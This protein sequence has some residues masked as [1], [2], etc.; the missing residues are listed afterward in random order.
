MRNLH[1]VSGGLAALLIL[2]GCASIGGSDQTASGNS[3]DKLK[4]T[5]KGTPEERAERRRS[6][7]LNSYLVLMDSPDGSPSQVTIAGPQGQAVVGQSGGAAL[8]DGSDTVFAVSEERFNADF[9]KAIGARPPL[10]EHFRLYFE[11]DSDRLTAESQ[12][13][14]PRIL[15]AVKQR[16][17]PDVSVVGHTDT[18]GSAQHNTALGMKR[19]KASG[20]LLREAGIDVVALSIESHGERNLLVETPDGTA[21]PRNRR[22]E[23]S[24]R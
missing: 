10:P 19:A 2:G 9:G 14:I 22:V 3:A 21:E 8:L 20:R 12:A 23:I 17:A 7:C 15:E 11:N 13:E 24:V 18:Q 6:R 16:P 1:L 4:A 5:P